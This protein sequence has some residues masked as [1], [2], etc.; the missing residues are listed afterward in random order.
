MHKTHYYIFGLTA[1]YFTLSL[2][3]ILH[4]EIWL[5][6][7][8]HW[9]LARESTTLS[10][11][12]YNTRYEGHPILWNILLYYITRFTHNPFWMQF[13]HIL[14]STT[15]I[16]VFLKKAPF[17]LLFKV[18]FIFGYF[19]F[20]EYNIISRNYML[21]ILFLFLAMNL[22]QKRHDKFLLFTFFL[23]IASNVH[24]LFLIISSVLYAFVLYE[25]WNEKTFFKQKNGIVYLIFGFGIILSIIQIIPASDTV[26][27]DKINSL[28][29]FRKTTTGFIAMWKGLIIIP[30]F[31]TIHFWNSN[32]FINIS[33]SLTGFL[34]LIIYLLPIIIFYK[35]KK[36]T[37]FIYASII[38][39]QFFFFITQRGNARS[40]GMLFLILVIA[41]WLEKNYKPNLF[42]FF[43]NRNINLLAK[44]K[45]F[46]IY[47]ILFIHLFS[48]IA[49]YAIDLKHSFTP[50]KNIS[51]Y[52]TTNDL[53]K[54][55]IITRYCDAPL[56]S[57]LQKNIYSLCTNDFESFCHWNIKC[58]ATN[59]Q[60][61]NLISFL[62]K[63]NKSVIFVTLNPLKKNK[64]INIKLLKNDYKGIIRNRAYYLY[65][66]QYK[67]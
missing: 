17:K 2:I 67:Y 62:K 58:D 50:S 15:T 22:Y 61:L 63:E 29:I 25:K 38:G 51:E 23:V 28:S 57:Y 36:T 31:R 60:T 24:L 1:L 12:F 59:Q 18:L 55:T 34:G 3:G 16:F 10:N 49:A 43:K 41:L 37:F 13:L 47:A 9:L 14:I 44:F 4:H 21:G 5:D 20:Y 53:H 8:H 33:K 56:S 64:N 66:V 65:E 6:E 54:K 40:E 26:F 35:N 52:L 45:K 48:G 42:S 30:D 19:M 27:F 39:M 7:A 32:L 46:S 11:L